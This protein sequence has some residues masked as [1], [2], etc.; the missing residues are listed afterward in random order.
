M[1]NQSQTDDVEQDQ[2]E[3]HWQNPRHHLEKPVLLIWPGSLN[4]QWAAEITEEQH[5]VVVCRMIL[6]ETDDGE[7]EKYAE[8]VDPRDE[9]P[10]YVDEALRSYDE[11]RNYGP[12]EDVINPVAEGSEEESVEDDHETLDRYFDAEAPA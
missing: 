4:E 2:I 11:E 1:S 9:I 10:S 6:W 7:I 8:R 3:V 5:A 12:V